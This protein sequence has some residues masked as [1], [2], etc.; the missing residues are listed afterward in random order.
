MQ[1]TR[2]PSVALVME[3]RMEIDVANRKVHFLRE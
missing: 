1:G 3:V 2:H